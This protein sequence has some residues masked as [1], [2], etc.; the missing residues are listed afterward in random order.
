MA[1]Q[2]KVETVTPPS[3]SPVSEKGHEKEEHKPE[4]PHHKCEGEHEHHVHVPV[5]AIPWEHIMPS[6]EPTCNHRSQP[7]LVDTL[8][9]MLP[10]FLKLY[11]TIHS[12]PSKSD[13]ITGTTSLVIYDKPAIHGSK[14]ICGEITLRSSDGTKHVRKL[15]AE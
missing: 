7:S 2:P 10:E 1:E 8:I 14:V 6:P 13:E 15:V 12:T 3:I 11:N 9:S 4:C 5:G